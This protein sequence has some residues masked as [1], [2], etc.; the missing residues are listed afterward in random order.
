[1]LCR[2]FMPMQPIQCYA[3][4]CRNFMQPMQCYAMLCRNFMPMQP[5]R[6]RWGDSNRWER[7]KGVLDAG[8]CWM[9]LD[10][11][12]KLRAEGPGWAGEQFNP[13]KGGCPTC[14]GPKAL[15]AVPL[16]W[17]PRPPVTTGGAVQ[18]RLSHLRGPQG[19]SG[20]P[21]CVGP[22]AAG[23]YWRGEGHTVEFVRLEVRAD[24][25]LKGMAQEVTT[26]GDHRCVILIEG[27]P[28]M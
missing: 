8:W 21:T 22:Q 19:P 2:N 7:T 27:R 28:Y 25:S 10:K 17:A 16:A 20:C 24:F 15:R 23:D 1:M 6:R 4:L 5:M 11:E 12:K 9:V 3:M 14:V 18:G 26:M 13:Y